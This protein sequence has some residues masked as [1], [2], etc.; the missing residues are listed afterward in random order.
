VTNVVQDD[1][2]DKEIKPL[3]SMEQN[4]KSNH[5]V[6]EE[7]DLKNQDTARDKRFENVF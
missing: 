5:E 4:L 1:Y 2:D 7:S 6:N 3:E